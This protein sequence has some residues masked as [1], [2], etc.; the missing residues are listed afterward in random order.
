MSNSIGL[1]LIGIGIALIIGFVALVDWMARNRPNT[2][3]GRI[4]RTIDEFIGRL[5][6]D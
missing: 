3:I 2:R 5:P 1:L 4:C 6:E